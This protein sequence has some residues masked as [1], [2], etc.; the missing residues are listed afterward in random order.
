MSREGRSRDIVISTSAGV[1]GAAVAHVLGLDARGA[2]RLSWVV[3]NA[4]V[5]RI[6]YDGERCSLESFNAVS[7][8]ETQPQ[9]RRLLTHR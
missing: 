6:R 4:S 9:P 2:L 8:L 7:H 3:F 5:T 1:I